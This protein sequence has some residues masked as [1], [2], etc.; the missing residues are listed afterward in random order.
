MGE[1][2]KREVGGAVKTGERIPRCQ[3]GSLTGNIW[4]HYKDGLLCVLPKGHVGAHSADPEVLRGRG[5]F[6]TSAHFLY[7]PALEGGKGE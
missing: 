6:V 7:R 4:K 5:L 2:R 3:R 1:L